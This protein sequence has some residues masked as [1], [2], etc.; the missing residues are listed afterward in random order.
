MQREGIRLTFEKI[1]FPAIEKLNPPA[2]LVKEKGEKYFR[3]GEKNKTEGL[4]YSFA[5]GKIRMSLFL[6]FSMD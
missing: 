1:L 5:D 3:I 6:V 4:F 2:P